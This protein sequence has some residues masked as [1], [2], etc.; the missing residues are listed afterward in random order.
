[1]A[2]AEDGD[3]EGVGQ[4]GTSVGGVERARRR[5]VRTWGTVVGVARVDAK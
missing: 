5:S 3:A 1:M 4:T 2:G